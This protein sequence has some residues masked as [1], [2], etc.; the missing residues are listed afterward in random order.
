MADMGLGVIGRR[1]V[2]FRRKFRWKFE[3]QG[4]IG[5]ENS[6]SSI[7]MLP[8]LK[9][10]RPSIS[11]KEMEVRHLD[12]IVYYPGRQD[13]K[14]INVTLYHLQC[15]NNPIFDWLKLIYDPQDNDD[16]FK[17]GIDT[18]ASAG[19][20]KLQ[21]MLAAG[22]S[23]IPSG[24]FIKRNADCVLYDG[25]GKEMEKWSYE[26]VWPTSIDW[27]ELDMESSDIVYVDLTLRYARAS[28]VS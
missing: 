21:A 11:I 24:Q 5:E 9:A 1:D 6:R 22:G 7:R 23:Q 12:E 4:I 8:P 28:I 13:W 26:C 18:A 2:V 3:I 10:A 19:S 27:G 14:T 16:P 15:N 20:Q 17:Y 25:C